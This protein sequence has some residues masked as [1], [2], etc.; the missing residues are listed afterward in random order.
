MN[1]T[2]DKTIPEPPYRVG[3]YFRWFNN[4]SGT[5]EFSRIRIR[6]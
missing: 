3:C 4:S 5:R 2:I 6:I 1:K